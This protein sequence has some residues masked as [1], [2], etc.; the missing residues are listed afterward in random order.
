[1]WGNLVIS[2][3]EKRDREKLV[4]L[5]TL[6]DT[7]KIKSNPTGCDAIG[8]EASLR[9]KDLSFVQGLFYLVLCL[10]GR[11]RHIAVKD[12]HQNIQHKT[13]AEKTAASG[14]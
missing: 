4:Q 1:M 14:Y 9:G 2:N 13:E 7:T 10:F 8:V 12:T 11:P 6:Y 5:L 3:S